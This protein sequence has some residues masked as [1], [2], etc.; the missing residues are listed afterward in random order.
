MKHLLLLFLPA[1]L[2]NGCSTKDS[3][4][5]QLASATSPYLREHADNPV[6]WVE[7]SNDAIDRAARENKP[8]IV[9]IGYASCHWCHVMERETFMDTTV[10][11]IMNDNFICI[12]VDREE[13]PD[14]DQVYIRAAEMLSGNAGWPLNAFALPDGRPFYAGT[15]YPK[16]QWTTLL[17]QVLK[18]YKDNQPNLVKQA[19]AVQDNISSEDTQLFRVNKNDTSRIDTFLSSV[20]LWSSS[21]DAVNGGLGGNSRFPMPS[22]SEFYLQHYYLTG[23]KGSLRWVQT[24]LNE[25]ANGGIYDQLGGGFSRYTVDSQWKVPHFEKMLYD[26]G[27]L[28]SLYSHA[29]QVTKDSVYLAVIDETLN[30]VSKELTAPDGAFFCS[31]NAENEGEEGKFYVWTKSEIMN[32]LSGDD[33]DKFVKMYGVVDSGNWQ[34]GKNILFIPKERRNLK[35]RMSLAS[36]RA[37]V[38]E[39]R[40]KRPKPT[41]DEKILTSWNAMMLNGY[42]DAYRATGN[43][44]YLQ[45]AITN[46]EF[47]Q[48]S[49]IQSDGEVFHTIG[50]DRKRI[51]GF[52]EDYSWSAKAFINL[53][54]VTFDIRWLKTAREI[55]DYAIEEFTNEQS[56]LLFYGPKDLSNPIVRKTELYDNVIPSSNS[57]FAEVLLRLAEYFQRKEYYELA[58]DAIT[59]ASIYDASLGVYLSNWARVAQIMKYQPY[60][61]AITGPNAV[62]EANKMQQAYLP[63]AYFMGGESE[64]D[65]PLLEGKMMSGKT[66]FFVCRKRVCKQPTEDRITALNQLGNTPVGE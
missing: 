38:L 9:S 41:R 18:A 49:H 28:V 44:A 57:V 16:E 31:I 51:P 30:F 3:T 22:I 47:L 61:V 11:R 64:D 40:N 1:A 23:N 59:S 26:N 45:A 54:E 8:I 43:R 7:W 53:Y 52:L 36:A 15:Y 6:A 17:Q 34:A 60:E 46:A 35:D 12:K 2:F 42:V 10:A 20:H 33:A 32:L 50:Q 29:F 66:V 39:A 48:Q 25:M 13:R 55:A 14:L 4:G 37:T 65:L 56:G 5:N 24:T 21:L 58:S 62:S 19:K 63:D 27:Q